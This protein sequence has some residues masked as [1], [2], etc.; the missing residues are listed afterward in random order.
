MPGNTLNSKTRLL[1]LIRVARE[2]IYFMAF[3]FT[4]DDLAAGLIERAHDGL[5]VSGVF[6][7][8]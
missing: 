1:E 5:Q 6:E 7:K 2:S 4:D 8:S 3:A